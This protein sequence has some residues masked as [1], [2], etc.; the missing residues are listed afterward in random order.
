M[1]YLE[2]TSMITGSR[3][4]STSFLP[5][6]CWLRKA[7]AELAEKYGSDK[8]QCNTYLVEFM[9]VRIDVK[10][11][12]L[13]GFSPIRCRSISKQQGSF[14]MTSGN[15][16]SSIVYSC[17]TRASQKT[18]K[19]CSKNAA[20]L[21]F[22]GGADRARTGDLRRDRPKQTTRR[23]STINVFGRFVS[24]SFIENQ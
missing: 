23:E 22:T 3:A 20:T 6:L 24:S 2:N 11:A 10:P 16:R 5:A 21:D 18:I 7:V 12:T 13:E 17:F 4:F 9:N 1:L 15:G 19:A 14:F 8:Y